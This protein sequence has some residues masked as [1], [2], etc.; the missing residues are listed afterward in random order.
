MILC[1]LE[2]HEQK[3]VEGSEGVYSKYDKPHGSCQKTVATRPCLGSRATRYML[4]LLQLCPIHLS[5]FKSRM[6]SAR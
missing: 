3:Q 5:G 1:Y 6:D 4:I 2:S